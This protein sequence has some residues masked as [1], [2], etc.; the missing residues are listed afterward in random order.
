MS[1]DVAEVTESLENELCSFSKLC[2]FTYVTADSDSPSF[3]SLHLRHSSIS[4]PSLASPTSQL[5]LQPFRCFTYVTAHSPTLLS[6]LLRHRIFTYCT[7]AGE[8]PRH[9]LSRIPKEKSPLVLDQEIVEAMQY[10]H[11]DQSIH[12]VNVCVKLER[13]ATEGD[14]RL[15][16][17]CT[18]LESGQESLFQDIEI[19]HEWSHFE[20]KSLYIQEYETQ[21]SQ[22][23]D[24]KIL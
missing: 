22:F 24:V 2:H 10:D 1:C 3:P 13:M 18:T 5:I 8:P 9:G 4:V 23:Q 11:H 19:W 16:G 12:L 7:S 6:P 17:R 15:A 21:V 20:K 14:L